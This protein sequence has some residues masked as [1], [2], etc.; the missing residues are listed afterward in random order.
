VNMILIRSI[1]KMQSF[2]EGIRRQGK[3]IA[4][5]PT[6]GYFHD[7]HLHLMQ[8]AKKM[9]DLVVVS[10]YVNPTQ[11]GPTEDFSQY[12]RDLDRDLEM[13]ERVGVDAVICPSDQEMYPSG[14]QTYVNVDKVT[15][16]LCGI[17]RPGH[18]RGVTTVCNKLFNIVRPHMAIFGRKDFQQLIAIH[19]MIK[20]LNMGIE[21]IGL[22]TVRESDGLAMSSRN[23]YLKRDER[24]SALTLFRALKAAQ[25][26]YFRGE[27]KSSVIISAAERIIKKAPFTSID[28]IQICDMSTLKDV[29]RIKRKTIIALAVKVGTT[30]LIDNHI[31]GE[32]LKV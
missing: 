17:S 23:K 29:D 8:Q 7:G 27:R 22:P 28:Y 1:K 19:R 31:F 6:M 14:Y 30:R 32:E 18:F 15:Q 5:V 11:F 10:I 20:D 3:K 16:H 12:P 9:A 24:P 21:V 13:A 4:F 25:R 26:L 2:S